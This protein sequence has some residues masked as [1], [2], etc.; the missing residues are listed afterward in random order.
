MLGS[1]AAIGPFT[2]DMY[3]PGFPTIAQDFGVDEK[4]ISYT[5]TSYFIGISLGQLIYGPILDKFGRKKP[6]ITGLIIYA[7]ASLACSFAPNLLALIVLRF[8]QAMGASVGMVAGNSIIRDRFETKEVARMLSSILLVM[9]AAPIIAPTLGSFFIAHF[10]WQ[11]IFIFLFAVAIFVTINLHFFLKGTRGYQQDVSLNFGE[12]LRNYAKVLRIGE[13]TKFTLAGSI[14]MAIMFAYIG[15]IPFILMTIYGLS[16]ANFGVIFGLNAGG[17]ILGSQVNRFM[18]K[19]FHLF[20]LTRF[21][22]FVQLALATLIL[23]LAYLIQIPVWLFVS[24]IFILL[25]L[26]GFINPNS[27]ALSLDKIRSNVGIA[28][29]LNGSFR[30]GFG[31]I[32]TFLIGKF[33]DG[34]MFPLLWFILILSAMGFGFLVWGRKH[35]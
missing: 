22:S 2:I 1:V 20:K 21:M 26:L 31:A 12:I 35:H 6:L 24:L 34:T 3:L 15:S 23:V 27:S 17:F 18:L 5:L 16:E 33:Y 4:Q 14:S 30:M 8:I 10:G 9:G 13:F 11:S 32:A 25:F 29:A 7:L 19:R 28:S